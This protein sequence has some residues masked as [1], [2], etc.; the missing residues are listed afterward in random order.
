MA[1]TTTMD[2]GSMATGMSAMPSDMSMMSMNMVFYSST[3]TP[4]YGDMWS[5]TGSGTYAGTCIFL[6]ILAVIFRSLFAVSYFLEKRWMDRERNRRF[7]VVN[8]KP[9]TA[10]TIQAD[11]H[12]KTGTLVTER[13]SEESVR[14]VRRDV[15][16]VMPWRLSVDLPRSLLATVIAGVGYLL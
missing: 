3:M 5:P 1:A 9:T 14:I 10:E 6:I 8:G 15:R 12:A 11:S 2:M 7:I 4:L 13:G 16:G